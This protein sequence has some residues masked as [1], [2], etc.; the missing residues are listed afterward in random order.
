MSESEPADGQ[1]SGKTSPLL[2][3]AG[4]YVRHHSQ[5]LI[6][7][8]GV[9][10]TPAGYYTPHPLLLLLILPFLPTPSPSSISI[11]SPPII[12]LLSSSHHPQAPQA[13]HPSVSLPYRCAF[14]S[15]QML[16]FLTSLLTLSHL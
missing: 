1:L 3:M 6:N 12:T 13:I 9:I 15:L 8:H 2:Q 4:E 16:H 10:E 14:V 7:Y 5:R 11:L